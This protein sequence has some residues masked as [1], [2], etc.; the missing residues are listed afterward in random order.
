SL[1]YY[2]NEIANFIHLKTIL[3]TQKDNRIEDVV[4]KL[5]DPSVEINWQIQAVIKCLNY[6]FIIISGGPG[7]VKTTTFEN[8]FLDIKM[9]N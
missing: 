6:Y 1:W 8:L 5:F 3:H 9:L 7:T 2:E 4:D